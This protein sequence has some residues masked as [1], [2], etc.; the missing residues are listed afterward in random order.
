[1]TISTEVIRKTVRDFRRLRSLLGYSESSEEA[2]TTSFFNLPFA[3][4]ESLLRDSLFLAPKLRRYDEIFT[5]LTIEEKLTLYLLASKLKRSSI[6]VEI[7]SF[8]GSSACFIALGLNRGGRLY[9]VDT[10]N[11]DAMDD[12]TLPPRDTFADFQRNTQDLRRII[13]PLRGASIS[14]AEVFDAR[15]DLLFID[16]DHSYDGCLNDWVSWRRFLAPC[17]IV[18]FHDI[19]WADGVIKVVREHVSPRAKREVCM[20]NI[21]VAW[22]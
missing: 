4:Q 9:C 20:S 13:V 15:I 2:T 6:A 1:M 8:L 21:Y 3:S 11:N 17:A 19:G 10:W 5:H 18:A 7:G 14:V 16:G 12:P 22:L